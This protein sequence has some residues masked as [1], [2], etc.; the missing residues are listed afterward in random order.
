MLVRFVFIFCFFYP[1]LFAG[2]PA[3]LVLSRAEFAERLHGF[4]LGQSIANWTGLVT[5]MCRVEPPFYT[6]ADWGRQADP[7]IWGNFREHFSKIDFFLL[8]PD[9]V[10]GADDDTDIEYL[11]QHLLYSHK[12]AVL[13][14]EQIRV[15]WLKHIYSNEDAPISATEFRR[16]NFLWVSN[17]AAYYLMRDK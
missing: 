14:G 16:E 13:T 17:E 6:R 7:N 9:R 4:W 15:G 8:S 1:M 12:T 2:T 11:Y 5:E 10:W 3:T